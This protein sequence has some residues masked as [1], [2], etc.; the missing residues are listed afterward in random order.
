M[1]RFLDTVLGCL[2]S[3]AK[4]SVRHSDRHAFDRQQR[5]HRNG[6]ASG[7][8]AALEQGEGRFGGEHDFHERFGG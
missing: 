2:E 1:D 4:P 3:T 8:A 6:A 7:C 5:L